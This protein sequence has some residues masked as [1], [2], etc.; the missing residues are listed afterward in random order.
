MCASAGRA[1]WPAVLMSAGGGRVS[2][3][4][5]RLHVT[6]QLGRGKP[7]SHPRPGRRWRSSR[8]E[9]GCARLAPPGRARRLG[10]LGVVTTALPILFA[11]LS[12]HATVQTA[13][14]S[15]IT[16]RRGS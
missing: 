11:G 2:S 9:A 12:N 14:G 10:P 1:A 13:S 5:A 16:G 8:A 15:T 3:S 6:R 7:P 4:S